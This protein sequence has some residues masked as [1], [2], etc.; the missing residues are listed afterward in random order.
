MTRAPHV[1]MAMIVVGI[2]LYGCARNPSDSGNSG[3]SST[4][5]SQQAKAKRWEEDF[6]AAASARDQYRQKLLAA[7]EKQAELQRQLE[8]ERLA[9]ATEREALK[10]ELKI[11]QSERDNLQTQYDGFRKNLRDLLAQAETAIANPNPPAIPTIPTIPTV[12]AAPVAP[13]PTAPALIGSQP[14]PAIGG[15]TLSN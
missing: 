7:E 3:N 15:T 5:S 13:T 2:G 12:P 4:T 6:H 8:Q 11:R 9:A 10:A 14:L 1:L